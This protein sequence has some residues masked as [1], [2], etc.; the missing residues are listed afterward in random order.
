[1]SSKTG[2]YEWFEADDGLFYYNCIAGNG[3]IEHPSE[4]YS[5]KG[6]CIQAIGRDMA[7]TSHYDIVQRP[8]QNVTSDTAVMGSGS[9]SPGV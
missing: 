5:T 7:D 8:E 9:W 6:N 4:G 3:E 2:R 1:M